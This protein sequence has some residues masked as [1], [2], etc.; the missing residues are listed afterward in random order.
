MV[1]GV[2]STKQGSEDDRKETFNRLS[3]VCPLNKVLVDR[4]DLVGGV[5]DCAMAD[6]Q[7]STRLN[8]MCAMRK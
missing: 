6:V 3:E 1:E 5:T 2:R 4:L 8:P 7:L